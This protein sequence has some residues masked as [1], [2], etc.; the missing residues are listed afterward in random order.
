V[1]GEDQVDLGRVM[2]TGNANDWRKVLGHT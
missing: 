1:P 2:A